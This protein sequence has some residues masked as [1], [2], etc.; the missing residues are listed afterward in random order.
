MSPGTTGAKPNLGVPL[1]LLES[2]LFSQEIYFKHK[3]LF[4]RRLENK[5]LGVM[6]KNLIMVLCRAQKGT[7]QE[8]GDAIKCGAHQSWQRGGC[9]CEVPQSARGVLENLCNGKIPWAEQGVFLPNIPQVV[10]TACHPTDR[11]TSCAVHNLTLHTHSGSP[12]HLEL[13][14]SQSNP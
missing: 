14:S 11:S 5:A 2:C 8:G 1:F 4:L 6:G 3:L 10:P 9:R 13:A 7:A 12:L